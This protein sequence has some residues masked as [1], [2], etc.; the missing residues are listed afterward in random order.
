MGRIERKRGLRRPARAGLGQNAPASVSAQNSRRNS[1]SDLLTQNSGEN[2]GKPHGNPTGSVGKRP[3]TEALLKL[4]VQKVPGDPRG[5][6]HAEVLAER[7]FKAAL[8]GS[9]AAIQE[10][11]QR[12]FE[13]NPE[14]IYDAM[15]NAVK[16][17]NPETFAV[18]ADRAFGKVRERIE[19]T[20]HFVGRRTEAG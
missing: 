2:S 18:L 20:H 8:S 19:V 6:T 9:T 4:A 5:R 11:A 10:I 17:G 16:K 13:K 1:Q 12:V 15:L 14:A 3:I 7:L